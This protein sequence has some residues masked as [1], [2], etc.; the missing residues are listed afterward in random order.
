MRKVIRCTLALILFVSL[1]PALER[2][3]WEVF[4]GR[5]ARLREKLADGVIVLFGYTAG[6]GESLRSSFRQENNFYYLTGWNEPGAILLLAPPMQD[7]ES[8]V[9]A[10]VSEM[11]R[12]AL[13][14]PPRNAQQERWTGIKIGPSDGS[15]REKTGFDAVRNTN[16]FEADLRRAVSG[17]G[18]IY[19]VL[20]RRRASDQESTPSRAAGLEK[21]APL[22]EVGD[23]RAV[24]TDMR[25]VKS[26]G[27]IGLIQKAT[28]ATIAAHL[29]AWKRAKP[30]VAEYQVASTMISVFMDMGCARPAYAPIVGA[31][32]NSTV[33]HYGANSSRM[34]AGQ[35]LLMDVGGEYS[36]YATD[37]TRTI[38]VGGKFTPRQREIYEIV[39][40]AQ[41]AAL[42]AVKP[43]MSTARTGP[44]SLHQI[45]YEY[46]NTH[47]K[48][49]EGNPLGKYFIHGLGHHVGLEVHDPANQG[50]L[51][52]PGMVI[53]L[54]PGI[55]IP[56]ENLGVRI[57][58]MVLVTETGARLLSAA[59]PRE[60]EEIERAMRR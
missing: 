20:P 26:P 8:P 6:E 15:L 37:V 4:A 25:V 34:D 33:L 35:V 58:D 46:I 27:E 10:E 53:T 42:A 60:A 16:L 51:L 1:A 23:A 17:F 49:R 54:E 39:L 18:R 50:T 28:D 21:I 41:K 44:N 57:E 5:R 43:G 56:E 19:T 2:E 29:A 31:G 24:I 48:D 52:Q 14:L 38:P 13:Y 22:A 40:G 11:P 32:F 7:K 9:F 12:E 59:L 3:P 30:G 36:H 47:G 45:A 55:Y